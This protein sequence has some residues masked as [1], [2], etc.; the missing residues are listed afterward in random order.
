MYQDKNIT[1]DRI[2]SLYNRSVRRNIKSLYEFFAELD[3]EI[4]VSAH[5]Q[6]KMPSDVF[7]MSEA[8]FKMFEKN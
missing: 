6:K 2:D 8:A 5:G 7:V 3:K 4:F 1:T